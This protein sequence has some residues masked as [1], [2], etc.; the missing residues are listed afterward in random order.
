MGALRRCRFI[1]ATV[2][3]VTVGTTVLALGARKNGSASYSAAIVINPSARATGDL[4][5]QYIGLSIESGAL[6]S[7]RITADGD[8]PQLLR[9]LGSSVLRFG[10]GSSDTSFTSVSQSELRGLVALAEASNWSVLY[11]ENLGKYDAAR[12]TT[13]AAAVSSALGSKMFAF[14][15]GNEPDA[16]S[17][18]GLRQ[19]NYSMANYLDQATAC[20]HAIRTGARHASL[21]GPDTAGNRHWFSMYA[22][23]ERGR[24]SWLGQHYYPMGCATPGDRPAALVSTLLSPGLASSEARG[25]RW[26]VAAAKAAGERLLITETNSACGGGIPGLSDAYASALWVI[27]YMLIG[28]EQ[29]VY[30]MYFHSGGLDSYC[31]GYTVLCQSGTSSYRAQPIYYGLVLTHL[32]GTG[33]FLPVKVSTSPPN[34]GNV[35]AFAIKPQSGG[36]RLMLEN[37]SGRQLDATINSGVNSSS[38]TV[39]S[40]TGPG[41]LSTSGVQIQGMSVAPDGNLSPG[42]PGVIGCAPRSCS[43]TLAPYSADVIAMG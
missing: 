40:L 22:E 1:V 23:R 43:I 18:N 12:V 28:A 21:E 7:G 24:V 33:H 32:L 20:L 26:Y 3:F 38:V 8:L 6:N 4:G 9:N 10:G 19:R 36:P 11:T 14:A 27:A 34:G 25:L 30:G 39:L 41:P 2:L 5:S 15:C 29:G 42:H 37:L 35:A 17:H 16:Y 31:A 13:D